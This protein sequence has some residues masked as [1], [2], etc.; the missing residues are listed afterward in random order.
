MTITELGAALSM[1]NP[2]KAHS[3]CTFSSLWLLCTIE[4]RQ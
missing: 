3:L 1:L 4:A 2:A